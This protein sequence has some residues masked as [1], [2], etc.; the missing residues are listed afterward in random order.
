MVAAPPY[1]YLVKGAITEVSVVW[2][3]K[4]FHA[5]VP[6]VLA[7]AALL[8][9]MVGATLA[10]SSA[11]VLELTAAAP[12]G[13]WLVELCALIALVG[14]LL[15]SIALRRRLRLIVEAVDAT[16]APFVIYDRDD[17]LILSNERY[18]QALQIPAEYLA[19]GTSYADIARRTLSPW[20]PS[21]RLEFEIA[22]RCAFLRA[23]TGLPTDRRYPDG[24]WMRV[25]KSRTKS[26]AN[27]GIAVDVSEFYALKASLQA[28]VQRFTALGNSAPVGICQIDE[29]RQVRFVNS[30]LLAMLGVADGEAMVRC[31]DTFVSGGQR[32]V[33]FPMLLEHLEAVADQ[34]DVELK[35]PAQA[36]T[37]LVKT[38]RVSF[39]APDD[40]VAQ[41]V[42]EHERILIFVDITDRKRAEEKIRYLAM[43]DML[44]GAGNRAAFA[45]AIEQA[46]EDVAETSPLTLIAID[47]DR[48]KPVNDTHGHAAGDEV[49]KQLAERI[50]TAL[51][52]S[53]SL[54]RM[55]GDEFTIICRP[56]GMPHRHKFA[57]ALLAA[58]EQPFRLG[59]K[60]IT[61]SA[62]I[63]LSVMPSDTDNAQ[64]LLHYADLASYRAKHA[65][66]A[67]ICLFSEGLLATVDP[68]R[69]LEFEL[70][71]ALTRE[72]FEI[73]YQPQFAAEGGI[74][75]G[76]EAYVRWRRKR[77]GALLKPAEFIQSADKFE[78]IDKLDF[79]VLERTIAAYGA[80][81]R[82]PRCPRALAV[83]VAGASLQRAEFAERVVQILAKNAVPPDRLVIELSE[84][85]A[86]RLTDTLAASIRSLAE[87]GVRFMLDD[88]G[89]GSTS[90]KVIAQ[91]P[92]AGIK[93]DVRFACNGSLKDR[94]RLQAV[95]RS[96]ADI[97][98]RL[99]ITPVASGV[100][101]EDGLSLLAS[102]GFTV[103]QGHLFGPVGAHIP[104]GLIAAPVGADTGAAR[105]DGMAPAAG[106][107]A[108]PAYDAIAGDALSDADEGASEVGEDWL[109]G[110]PAP[111]IIRENT[112]G[113]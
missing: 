46:A 70:Q 29:S 71:D 34:A 53:M 94:Q 113:M 7:E 18:R 57:R 81:M 109:P 107:T 48:F 103:F 50:R 20:V 97:A 84:T 37:F 101:C 75:V 92:L 40:P 66:G 87:R 51:A 112:A 10:V 54:Y 64:T 17:R 78:L 106:E 3:R 14:A 110:E 95:M 86:I 43:H 61:L 33:G 74:P 35:L 39:P 45:K 1:A 79:L 38:A 59:D 85:D 36:R 28:Q 19:P 98:H 68:Q 99:G 27:V 16:W 30:A 102:Y 23:A 69:M 100:E 65:G 5:L 77:S 15:A 11:F 6:S 89:S 83:N 90:F 56:D 96:M 105:L 26:G 24:V 21:D 60:E 62:S 73:V 72:N 41:S 32:F 13:V 108:P 63:G 22:R 8:P 2:L 31:R 49:L 52:P 76:V 93:V 25:T 47:L 12:V 67:R 42:V 9:L 80:A 82:Q 104:T 55:G 44:T 58:I 91:L 88:F 4:T 111:A